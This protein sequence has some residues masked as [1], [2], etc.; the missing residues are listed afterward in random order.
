MILFQIDLPCIAIH[1]LKRDAA[2]AVHVQT[3]AARL[4]LQRMKIEAGNIE[5]LKLAR[6]M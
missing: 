2:R 1:P 5:G 4:A 6:M 3:V